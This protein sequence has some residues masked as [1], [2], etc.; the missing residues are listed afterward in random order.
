MGLTTAN[1][2]DFKST[3]FSAHKDAI[4]LRMYDLLLHV[5]SRIHTTESM[6]I[7]AIENR[8]TFNY[9]PLGDGFRK[10]HFI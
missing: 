10:Q 5:K 7:C 8:F 4:V 3:L 6:G 9:L 1:A 2:H